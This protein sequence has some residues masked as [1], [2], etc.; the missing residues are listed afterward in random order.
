MS[1]KVHTRKRARSRYK[2]SGT[3][4]W[5]RWTLDLDFGPRNAGLWIEISAPKTRKML[6]VKHTGPK[7]ILYMDAANFV[8][9]WAGISG[10]LGPESSISGSKVQAQGPAIPKCRLGPTTDRSLTFCSPADGTFTTHMHRFLSLCLPICDPGIVFSIQVPKSK[11]LI[12]CACVSYKL[13]ASC[14]F[15]S[16]KFES[17]IHRCAHFNIKLH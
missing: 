7:L 5:N 11:S 10:N 13:F 16:C 6:G 14:K 4:F 2:L 1:S 8:C 15:A 3:A 9:F 12:L 17:V